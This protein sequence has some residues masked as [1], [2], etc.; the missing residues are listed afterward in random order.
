MNL[1]IPNEV[2]RTL[3][4]TSTSQGCKRERLSM[5][6]GPCHQSRESLQELALQLLWKPYLC[7]PQTLSHAHRQALCIVSSPP[8]TIFFS[9]G[10][11]TRSIWSPEITPYCNVG[12]VTKSSTEKNI[13][14][15]KNCFNYCFLK[16]AEISPK[17]DHGCWHCTCL[18]APCSLLGPSHT[19]SASLFGLYSH[20]TLV[21]NHSPP[22]FALPTDGVCNH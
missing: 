4:I 5:P 10:K 13:S 2:E 12:V 8:I 22:F 9:L 18:S 15:S 21:C 16:K 3:Y 6:Y 19:A 20:Y 14:P 17:P 7:L 11:K 1:R